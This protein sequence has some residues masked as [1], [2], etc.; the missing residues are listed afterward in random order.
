MTS[1]DE[2]SRRRETMDAGKT[3]LTV[4]YCCQCPW[5]T[6]ISID[7]R[8]QYRVFAVWKLLAMLDSITNTDRQQSLSV[9]LL[10]AAELSKI[11]V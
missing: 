11:S 3:W 2:S 6:Q 9:R 7:D 5:T 10:C 4:A 1:I 8:G